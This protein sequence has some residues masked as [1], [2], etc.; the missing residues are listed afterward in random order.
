M[1]SSF[2]LKGHSLGF[3]PQISK[4]ESPALCS[5]INST[6]RKLLL[7]NFHL[8]N[9]SVRFYPH[10]DSLKVRTTLYSI[11]YSTTGKNS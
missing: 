1:L 10:A 4:L 2:P 6:G 5:V 9:N 7:S 8:D 11:I 3:H